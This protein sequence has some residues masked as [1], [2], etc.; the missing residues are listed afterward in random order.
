MTFVFLI[1]IPNP[2]LSL[3]F[4]VGTPK[5]TPENEFA[6]DVMEDVG[7]DGMEDDKEAT[8]I[9][10]VV[11]RNLTLSQTILTLI[12]LPMAVSSRRQLERSN[13]VV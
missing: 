13:N 6:G 11:I 9:R 7:E 12:F 8:S 10:L 2:N 4:F 1:P 5:R 3:I